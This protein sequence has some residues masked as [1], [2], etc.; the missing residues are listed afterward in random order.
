M[1]S[2]SPIAP[3]DTPDAA[4]SAF[5]AMQANMLEAQ[6]AFTQAMSDSHLAYLRASEVSMLQ[7]GG[8]LAASAGAAP[9][10][11]FL[12]GAA[13]P[14]APHVAAAPFPRVDP[15][16]VPA[17]PPA[18]APA[19]LRASAPAAPAKQESLKTPP[20]PA[21]DPAAL[22]LAVVA[23]KTGYP[24]EM[25]T[26]DME[27]EAG[28][29]ID[30]IKR[31]QILSALQEK[32]PQLADVDTNALAALNTLGEIV[33]LAGAMDGQA[34]IVA[35][36]AGIDATAL[37][38]EV[39]SEKTGYPVEMLT[40]DM[41]LEAGLGIDSIKR[42]QILSALQEKLPQLA[43]VDTNALAA[44]NTLGE[45]VALAG[46][47]AG[48]VPF[49]VSAAANVDVTALLLEVVSEKT[50][51]PVEMLT[52]DMELEAGLGI[53]S[54]KRV[55][56]LSALQEKLPQL[57]DVDTNALAALN[58]LGEI[59][60]LAGAFD[61]L[62]VPTFQA[63]VGAEVDA[64]MLLLDVVSEK[65]GYP[66]EM[67][68]LDMELEAGLGIDSIKRV[69]IL[70]ALQEKLPQLADVDTNAL[71]ALNT[72]GEIVALASA[73]GSGSVHVGAPPIL[74]E[75]TATAL[76]RVVVAL[77]DS[78]LPGLLTPALFDTNP[79]W[80]AGTPTALADALARELERLGIAVR[81]ADELP[82]D[83][84]ACI[85]F[86]A[87]SDEG[88][89]DPRQL[90]ETVFAAIKPCAATMA[91]EGRLLVVVQAT[92]GDFAIGAGAGERAWAVGIGAIAKTAALEW[93]HVTVRSIDIEPGDLSFEQLAQALRN[94]LIGGG[95]QLEVGLK[96]DG[97]R[98]A[99]RLDASQP[100]SAVESAVGE[101]VL[102]VSGGARG[103]TAECL[104]A[105]LRERVRPI[106]IFGRTP[107]PAEQADLD[108]LS[109]DAA[110]KRALLAR[111]KAAGAAPT[112]IELGAEVRAVIAGRELRA[113][114]A[115]FAALGAA[116]RYEAVDIGDAAAVEAAVAAIRR[117]MGPIGGIV[118]AAG[119]LADKEIRQKTIE[120]FRSVL[121]TKVVGLQNLLA[122]TREDKL[123][124]IVCFSSIA[125]WRGNVGQCDYAAANQILNRVCR[126]ERWR[127]GDECLVKAIGW[128]PWAGGM[129]D[130][131]LEAHFA[132]LGVALIP[133]AEG[134]R[135]FVDEYLGRNGAE[136]EVIFGGG[137]D[138]FAA[139]SGRQPAARFHARFH[140]ET[141][142]YIG[143]H[144][145]RSNNV[146]PLVAAVDLARR[147]VSQW[148]GGV[149]VGRAEHIEVVAGMS[150]PAFDGN[151]DVF[152]VAC[153]GPDGAGRVAVTISDATGRLCYRMAVL[154]GEA[155]LSDDAG[156]ALVATGA[157]ENWPVDKPIYDGR[158]FHG[159]DLQV[160]E[161]VEGFSASGATGLLRSQG[162]KLPAGGA[163]IDILDG[164][165]Q[166]SVLWGHERR[167]RE[168][169][170]TGVRAMHLIEGWEDSP[171]VRCEAQ[172]NSSSELA[173]DWT[174]RFRDPAGKLLGLM[175]GVTLHDLPAVTN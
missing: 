131:G 75:A 14:A 84:R 149:P 146:V 43:D 136:V 38:L 116:V 123:D 171:A 37:L 40:L 34:S 99:P 16:I 145:I 120:Q 36:A 113:N 50:G 112:P 148:L 59:V 101:G 155:E 129:V 97:R 3:A 143:S 47:V 70:S 15:L 110:L 89:S 121:H 104:A 140:R 163:P 10:K 153:S 26:L 168:S 98:V 117:E 115:R 12:P 102:I 31:V 62:P 172:C 87:D 52:L 85:L 130:A 71:A 19:V 17:A 135:F 30:S 67:L 174:L 22:L 69:Q 170:P 80:I 147:T 21:S 61:E 118:H 166:L 25:L 160:L 7:L 169:L 119:V 1:P 142:G 137:L 154:P 88:V 83:A 74:A 63:A 151:G 18:I 33:A 45:I 55:Q 72:L 126:Q 64:T 56:I 106:A 86:Q 76:E 11:P 152:D 65:T 165:L 32:L 51:Y 94:E 23:E 167:G 42:V 107:L 20:P 28:L 105:L 93:P 79:L 82:A 54:I 91:K 8:G 158:L 57:A 6:K 162:A 73:S 39:V 77:G 49:A 68:T 95:T 81:R 4:W 66:V 159:P 128:G 90:S 141:H 173:T 60:A 134:A 122:A 124:R 161:I 144:V 46:A 96:A 175:E 92:G 132:A 111:H 78:P 29:G 27:L 103:V 139:T 48:P 108:G 53:D 157:V 58:T 5:E 125:A 164:G 13:M 2:R 41:E 100:A 24:V 133:L 109:D 44:L 35:E 150:L 127:R 138:A 156:G 114:L 9:P